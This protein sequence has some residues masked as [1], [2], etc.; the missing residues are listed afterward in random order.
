MSLLTVNNLEKS[1][2]IDTILDGISFRL[3]WGQKLGLVGRNGAGKTTLLR[4]LTGQME[5]DKGTVNFLKGVR[6]GYL[7]QEQMV[8]HGWTVYQEAQDAFGP[9]LE[10]EKRLR[11][12]ECQMGEVHGAA[13]DSVLEEYGLMHDRFEAMGGFD[14]L[15]DIG[16]VLKRLGFAEAD[17][18]KPTSKLSG[19]EKTRL[20]MAKLLLSG[21]DILLLDEPTNHL[22]LQATEW[23]E[24]FLH[25]FG[26]AVILVSHDRYFLDRV[27]TTIAE[28]ANAKLTLYTGNFAAYWQQREANR[29]RLEELFQRDIQ[30]VKRLTEFFEKWKNTPS[31][32]S[33]ALMRL[34]WAE[35]IKGSM[36]VRPEHDGKHM[37]LGLREKGR[38]GNEVMIV[39]KLSKRFGERRLF[40]NVSLL[41]LRG[42]RVG[43]VGPNGAGKSTL[44]RMLLGRETADS[45]SI[46]LGAN[47]SVGY[48]AQEA[49]DLDMGAT[50][51]DNMLDVAEMLPEE[52][53]THLGKFLFSGDDVFLPVKKLSGGE[54]NKLALAQL[55]YLRPNLLILDEPTNHLDID[56]REALVGML[57]KYDGTLIL[58]SHD[59]YLLDEVTNQ[60]LEIADGHATLFDGP[61]RVYRQNKASGRPTVRGETG[62]RNS[63]LRTRNS[64]LGT[65]QLAANPLTAG[66]NSHQLSKERQKAAKAAVTAEKKVT[67]SEDWMKRIEEALSE[68]MPGD[69]VIKLS[70][71]YERAQQELVE[72]METWEKAVAYAEGIGAT[73]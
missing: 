56:S 50:V 63:E 3:E 40:E 43:V 41:I 62:T 7:R 44:I 12:L 53:R 31:K 49:S 58:V 55:T 73:V 46:R 67:E 61:Y 14:N 13:L 32:R 66:M 29:K 36:T 51:L 4:I 24:G 8:E 35:R 6:F 1:F 60:T 2:G 26:G 15:R 34:R 10:M 11:D 37:K 69:D 57:R 59:R 64:E 19:G 30:E 65:T 33:Q 54:K 42:Q 39:D 22:D 5:A 25:D 71:D 21:P 16:Q 48:F 17:F 45:G 28:I 20:A 68:P 70:Q 18:E 23:L 72:A 52:A 27:V 47:V 38:S 9:V